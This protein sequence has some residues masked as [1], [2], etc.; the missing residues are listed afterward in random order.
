MIGKRGEHKVKVRIVYTLRE[1]FLLELF[2][3]FKKYILISSFLQFL[4]GKAVVE[5]VLI[6][7][8]ASSKN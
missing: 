5:N 2:H 7:F 6:E 8:P 4:I 3:T 1:E